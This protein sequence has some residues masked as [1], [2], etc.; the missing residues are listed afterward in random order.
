MP[1][2]LNQKI[3]EH[4]T[5]STSNALW[6]SLVGGI[7]LT[8]IASMAHV[9][10]D[11]KIDEGYH[12]IY[13]LASNSLLLFLIIIFIFYLI[14]RHFSLAAKYILF[15]GGSLALAIAFSVFSNWMQHIIYDS[16]PTNIN[17]SVLLMRDLMVAIAAIVISILIFNVSRRL[18]LKIEKEQLEAENILVKYEAL[19][20]QMDPHFLFNSLNTLSG[21]I[22]ADDDKA[23]RYLLQLAS[24]Y[25]YIMQGKRLVTLDDELHFVDSYS[26]MMLIRYGKNLT[27]EKKINPELSKYHMVPISIQLLIENALK[28]NVVSDRHPL[29]IKIETTQNKSVCISNVIQPKNDSEQSN[30]LGLANMSKR[31]QLLCNRDISIRNQNNIF[32]VELPLLSPS[33]TAKIIDKIGKV[34]KRKKKTL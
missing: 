9:D 33:E 17:N 18:E 34:E 11:W 31:Y 26:Q 16:Q 19:E 6:I 24:T 28:H 23:Q 25:R 29:T 10:K 15:F 4:H 32:S 2:P 30:G 13:S 21:L 20:N 5:F 3:R 27:I 12:I 22:G 8:A 14:K 7:I 1:I